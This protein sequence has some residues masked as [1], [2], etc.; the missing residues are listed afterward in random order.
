MELYRFKDIR[1]DR[2]L[3]Q[4]DIAK[5]LK[6]TQC[7]YSLYENGIRSIPIEKLITLAKFYNVSTDYLL[8]LTDERKPYSKSIINKKTT[9]SK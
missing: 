6:T 4:T 8:G 9:S 1:E 7:Q 5:V 3:L 2:D